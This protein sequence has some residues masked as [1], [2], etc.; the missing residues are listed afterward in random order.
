MPQTFWDVINDLRHFFLPL[1]GFFNTLIFIY[2]KVHNIR[3]SSTEEITLTNAIIRL[4]KQPNLVPPRI[5]VSSLE[6]VKNDAD[7]RETQQQL[8]ELESKRTP[9]LNLGRA[10][11]CTGKDKPTTDIEEDDA[12]DIFAPPSRHF[13]PN[14]T[15]KL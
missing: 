1:Q 2:H 4:I 10:L 7:A 5:I 11:S 9:S 6:I 15:L 13:Y 12:K 8:E 14:T 3:K